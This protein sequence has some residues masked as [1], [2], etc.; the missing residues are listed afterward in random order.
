MLTG[1]HCLWKNQCFLFLN[2][3]KILW[4]FQWPTS[5]FSRKREL[6]SDGKTCLHS[7]KQIY[8]PENCRQNSNN[9]LKLVHIMYSISDMEI[10]VIIIKYL[11]L[12]GS[13]YCHIESSSQAP[14]SDKN[15]GFGV[16]S[17]WEGL[18]VCKQQSWSSLIP[19]PHTT[20]STLLICVA[21][22]QWITTF[23]EF[24]LI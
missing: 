11:T 19:Q 5:W 15:L 4:L 1:T 21:L 16:Q 2:D 23:F 13:L 12:T 18:M 6:I 7:Y 9:W 17:V 3:I 10:I 8:I 20:P 14:S 22:R 24:H